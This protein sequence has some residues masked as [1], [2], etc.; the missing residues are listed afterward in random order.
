VQIPKG[1]GSASRFTF[2]QRLGNADRYTY[3]PQI[4]LYLLLTWAFRFPV[5]ANQIVPVFES[6]YDALVDEKPP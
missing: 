3:L 1:G 4:G 5:L 6:Q 2:Q